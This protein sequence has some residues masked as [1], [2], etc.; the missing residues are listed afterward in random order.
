VIAAPRFPGFP[1]T[2]ARAGVDEGL[3]TADV[4]FAAIAEWY[5]L[6]P[7]REWRA[8]PQ[9][10]VSRLIADELSALTD[11]ADQPAR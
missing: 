6:L 11:L 5:D 3:I 7:W 1:V 8:G 10:A 4:D 9:G 2:L